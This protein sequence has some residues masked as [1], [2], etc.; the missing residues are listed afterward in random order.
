MCF[1]DG[2]I[3]GSAWVLSAD[4]QRVLLNHHAKLDKW[5]QFGG[6]S[7]GDPDTLQV[8]LREAR[9]E[10]GLQLQVLSE[11]VFDI[12]IH[13]IPARGDSPSHRHYDV[14]FVCEV[15]G[16]EA[17]KRSEESLELRWVPLN[18]VKNFTTEQSMLRLVE[19]TKA[20][21]L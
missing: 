3:T 7:D 16:S 5:L 11:E 12:D 1:D 8:A 21:Q 19:K 14:R 9:E 6:H 4:R 20:F 15:V 10:S 13:C 18:E 2:H 17:F